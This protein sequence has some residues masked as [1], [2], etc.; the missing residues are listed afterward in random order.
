VIPYRSDTVRAI[1]GALDAQDCWIERRE[2]GE[3]ADEGE[4]LT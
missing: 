4:D 2:L 3:I 1:V